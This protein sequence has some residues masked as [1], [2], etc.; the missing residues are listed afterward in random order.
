MKI[1]MIYFSGTG[2]TKLISMALAEKLI[3]LHNQVTIRSIESNKPFE[4][5]QNYDSI[6]FSF[7]VYAWRAPKYFSNYLSNFLPVIPKIPCFI[8]NTRAISS[9][10]SNYFI[11]KIIIS[12]GGFIFD[13]ENFTTPPNDW[14][15]LFKKNNSLVKKYVHFGDD[16][17][18][19]I[20]NFAKSIDKR[21]KAGID[22]SIILNLNPIGFVASGIIHYPSIKIMNLIGKFWSVDQNN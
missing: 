9:W 10:W 18:H 11:A 6:G 19:R 14:M 12:Q 8:F 16:L 22:K 21:L 5:I 20:N 3:N 1:L 15:V 7:P 13:A 2:N 17:F 4:N